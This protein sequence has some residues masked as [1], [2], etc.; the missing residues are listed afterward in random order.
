MKKVIYALILPLLVISG[1]VFANHE[2]KNEP[3]KKASPKP[4][5]AAER[6]TALEQWEATTGG[7][8]YKNWEASPQGKKVLA[9][10][11]KIMKH[12]SDPAGTEAI[13]TDLS[14]PP[15][16]QLGFAVMA[17]INGEECILSFGPETSDQFKQLQTLKV[18]DKI[19]IKSSAVMHA[20]KYAYPIVPGE[21]VEREGK[22]IYKRTL[23]K[24][25]C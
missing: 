21:Y 6:K 15:G 13:I 9:S 12:T 4:L 24:G 20:P 8:M 2:T 11:V 17:S 19:I 1:L 22:I 3:S 25:G 23:G 16:T 5:N 18:N 7:I 14:L 10:A